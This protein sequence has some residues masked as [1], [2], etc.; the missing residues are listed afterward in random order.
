M[1]LEPYIKWNGKTIALDDGHGEE[2]PGK[3]SPKHK[4][5]YVMKENEFNKAVV[6][7]LA[8]HLR[9]CGFRVLL[10]AP[11][12]KDTPLSERVALANK[13]KVDFYLSIHANALNGKWG[14]HGGI[15]TY[16]H[17]SY[18]KT[19]EQAKIIHNEV[20]KGTKLADRGVKNGDWLYVCKNTSMAAVLVELGFMDSLFDSPLLRSDAYRKESAEELAKAICKIFNVTYISE[21]KP[22]PKKKGLFK[23]QVGAFSQKNNAEELEK[24]L[25]AAGFKDTF[26]DFE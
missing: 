9:R 25:H 13:Y 5:G 7:F 26:I 4:D 23:V 17:F 10:V 24:K 18:S 3:R 12:D 14:K 20:M 19:V 1:L 21:P 2:T 6:M 16:A 8:E 22:Q 11:T 15:E